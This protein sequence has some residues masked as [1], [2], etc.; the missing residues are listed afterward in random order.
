MVALQVI[1]NSDATGLAP[2]IWGVVLVVNIYTILSG[3]LFADKPTRTTPLAVAFALQIPCISSPFLVYTFG[4]GFRVSAG[5]IGGRFSANYR[6]GSDFQ[7]ALLQGHPWGIGVNL[8]ALLMFVMLLR[9]SRTPNT[10]LE[11]TATAPS[12]LD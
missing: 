9:Y 4:M 1:F 5:F 10:A 12:V 11:P 8:F 6:L 3:L 2:V 7:V